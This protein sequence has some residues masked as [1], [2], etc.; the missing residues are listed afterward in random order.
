MANGNGTDKGSAPANEPNV[1]QGHIIPPILS[2]DRVSS[3]GKFVIGMG[4]IS[5]AIVIS[6]VP[7]GLV[8]LFMRP[9][10][11]GSEGA[12]VKA[13]HWLEKFLL[14]TPSEGSKEPATDVLNW[15]ERLPTDPVFYYLI[16]AFAGVYLGWRWWLYAKLRKEFE[17]RKKSEDN[18]TL[19][20]RD[21]WVV[22]ELRERAV[23][24]RLQAGWILG[25][26]FFVVVYR[27][28]F[29]P[30]RCT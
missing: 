25:G 26:I 29:R 14:G 16:A 6:L 21:W 22:Q 15:L 30:L 24:L 20:S 4:H 9:E 23:A 27:S 13:I 3:I 1:A 8:Y 12:V 18:N 28:L 5:V 17:T 10:S 11:G 7:F 2:R 19:T